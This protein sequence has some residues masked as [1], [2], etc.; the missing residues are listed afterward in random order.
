MMLGDSSLVQELEHLDDHVCEMLGCELPGLG[1]EIDEYDR[2]IGFVNFPG[3]AGEY[4][5]SLIAIY[6]RYVENGD[7][8]PG[9]ANGE[10]RGSPLPTFSP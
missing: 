4:V 2:Q 5:R 9:V 6:R 7:L 8:A 10:I 1:E 3:N